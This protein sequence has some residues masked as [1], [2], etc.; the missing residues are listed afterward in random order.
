MTGAVAAQPNSRAAAMCLK[1][2]YQ[3]EFVLRLTWNLEALTF[4]G[5]FWP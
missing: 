4:L 1:N 5:L 2:G 3:K